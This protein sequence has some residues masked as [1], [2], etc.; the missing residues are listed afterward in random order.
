[1]DVL[2]DAAVA[3]RPAP[4]VAVTYRATQCPCGHA[5]CHDWHV[6]PVAMLQGV[7]FTK[8]QAEAVAKL[9]NDMEDK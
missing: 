3:R 8:E 6:W 4:G 9:L 5:S 1:M 2:A 7:H